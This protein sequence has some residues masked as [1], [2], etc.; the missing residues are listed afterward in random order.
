[1]IGGKS[2]E[3]KRKE[4]I[5]RDN[6]YTQTAKKTKIKTHLCELTKAQAHTGAEGSGGGA[7]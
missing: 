7:V 2:K 4:M 6:A 3:A 1:M 5:F